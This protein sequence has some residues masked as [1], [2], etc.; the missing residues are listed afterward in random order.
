MAGM[1][2][3]PMITCIP[4]F[5]SKTQQEAGQEFSTH[6][7]YLGHSLIYSF[8]QQVFLKAYYSAFEQKPN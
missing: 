8:I 6:C 1:N 5:I 3:N 4:F 2:E 7:F